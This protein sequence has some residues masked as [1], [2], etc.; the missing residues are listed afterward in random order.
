MQKMDPVTENFLGQKLICK[1]KGSVT[2]DFRTIY[3][4]N[5]GSNDIKIFRQKYIENKGSIDRKFSNGSIYTEES[6]NRK[7]SDKSTHTDQ[8]VQR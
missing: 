8:K 5:K 4:W 1:T 6:S 3:A 2:E 7:F